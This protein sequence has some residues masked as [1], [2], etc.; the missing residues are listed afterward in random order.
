MFSLSFSQGF[1]LAFS[2]VFEWSLKDSLYVVSQCALSVQKG[3]SADTHLLTDFV[4]TLS[5]LRVKV[6]SLSGLMN[7]PNFS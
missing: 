7:F 6:V 1:S 2:Q 3:V 4:A 5:G